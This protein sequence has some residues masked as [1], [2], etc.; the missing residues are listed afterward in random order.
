MP[1]SP[2]KEFEYEIYK[3]SPEDRVKLIVSKLEHLEKLKSSGDT[4]I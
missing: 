4:H 3:V 1:I 2:L